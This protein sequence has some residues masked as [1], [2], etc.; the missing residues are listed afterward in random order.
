MIDHYCI[1]FALSGCFG[2]AVVGVCLLFGFY[3]LFCGCVQW[4]A[5]V[6]YVV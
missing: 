2:D 5:L 1:G 3:M 4:F 6:T